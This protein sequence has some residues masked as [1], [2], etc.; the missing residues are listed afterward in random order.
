MIIVYVTLT[1]KLAHSCLIKL[2]GKF[3]YVMA[4]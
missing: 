3:S 4:M 2:W 1:M